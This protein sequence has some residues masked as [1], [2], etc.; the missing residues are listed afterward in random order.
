MKHGVVNIQSC[1]I[2]ISLTL[3]VLCIHTRDEDMAAHVL[4]FI[5][6]CKN[7]VMHFKYCVWSQVCNSVQSLI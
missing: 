4:Q 5:F 6:T 3:C 7:M 2:L 1:G